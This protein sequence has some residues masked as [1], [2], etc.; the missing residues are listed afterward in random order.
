MSAT[1]VGNTTA[2][3]VILSIKSNSTS[4]YQ[5]YPSYG[6][7]CLPAHPVQEMFKRVS[8][9]FTA[10]FR[11]KAFLHW[12]TGEG[13]DEME[14]TEAESNMNDLVAEYQQ[15]QDATIDEQEGEVSKLNHHVKSKNVTISHL[16]SFSLLKNMAIAFCRKNTRHDVQ[17]VQ[18]TTEQCDMPKMLPCLW[19]TYAAVEVRGPS[20]V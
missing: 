6:Y 5:F 12:Y 13:M 10:M 14:F 2:V 7:K 3:Q 9:Q 8:E 20:L 11:R 4:T 18:M 16:H 15:Y 19:Y 1:F 17:H